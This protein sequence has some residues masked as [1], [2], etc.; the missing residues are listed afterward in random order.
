MTGQK[1]QQKVW[2]YLTGLEGVVRIVR[3]WAFKNVV[4]GIR[5]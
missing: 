4:L 3:L 5:K 1:I 2:K